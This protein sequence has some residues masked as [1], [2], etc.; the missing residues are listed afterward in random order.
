VAGDGL[1]A[2]FLP[3]P[4]QFSRPFSPPWIFVSPLWRLFE[5][6]QQKYSIAKRT[7]NL[8]L[9]ISKPGRESFA[10]TIFIH[11]IFLKPAIPLFNLRISGKGFR[12]KCRRS[13]A[14]PANG[15]IHPG[16][17]TLS[18]PGPS[19]QNP[20]PALAA[21]MRSWY[22]EAILLPRKRYPSHHLIIPQIVPSE[23]EGFKIGTRSERRRPQPGLRP[24]KIVGRRGLDLP[25][26]AFEEKRK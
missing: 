18:S 15:T 14:V 22:C 17:A 5:V 3:T 8:F 4:F 12:R 21:G 16:G 7:S 24:E 23:R 26:A 9:N 10:Q 19:R 2:R 13:S 1:P 11:G 20:N 25:K 6:Y